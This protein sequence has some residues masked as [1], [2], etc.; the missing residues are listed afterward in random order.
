MYNLLLSSFLSHLKA[1]GHHTSV[2]CEHY[3]PY[4]IF[5]FGLDLE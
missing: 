1:N 2:T 5:G 3:A 4:K